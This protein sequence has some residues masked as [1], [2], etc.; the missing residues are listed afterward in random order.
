MDPV[1]PSAPSMDA[2]FAP[3]IIRAAA[4]AGLFTYNLSPGV[5]LV[6]AWSYIDIQL[7]WGCRATDP[8]LLYTFYILL[9]NSSK[10]TFFFASYFLCSQAIQTLLNHNIERE[11]IALLNEKSFSSF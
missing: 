10:K 2:V 3:F 1:P 11:F 9:K 4:M 7:L 5:T 6:L 8:P